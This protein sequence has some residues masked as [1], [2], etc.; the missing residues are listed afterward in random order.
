MGKKDDFDI[1]II[2]AG[3]KE[4]ITY[5]LIH[6]EVRFDKEF[7]YCVDKRFN[8]FVILHEQLTVLKEREYSN[9]SF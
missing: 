2:N 3:T 1:S 7:Y 4:S 8:D 5:Y 9:Q 6:L